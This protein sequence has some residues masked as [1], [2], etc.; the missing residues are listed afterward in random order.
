[1]KLTETSHRTSWGPLE[2]FPPEEGALEG[3]F[4]GGC[5][6]SGTWRGGGGENKSWK[7]S[8]K[9]S[10]KDLAGGTAEA[11]SE[12]GNEEDAIPPDEAPAARPVEDAAS[13]DGGRR[14]TPPTTRR[15]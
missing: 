9:A 11:R 2:G 13:S 7:K 15:S 3:R 10:R 6:W 1:M 14:K 8:P 12:P 4:S 5:P